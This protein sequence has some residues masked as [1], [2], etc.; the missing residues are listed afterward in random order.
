MYSYVSTFV[1]CAL[2]LCYVFVCLFFL[3]GCFFQVSC[4]FLSKLSKTS[5]KIYLDY[6]T[7]GF[8]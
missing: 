1:V 3:V 4:N 5:Y 6:L 8:F 7:V 2:S